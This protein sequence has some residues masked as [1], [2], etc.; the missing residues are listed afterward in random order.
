[1]ELGELFCTAK[2]NQEALDL[3]KGLKVTKRFEKARA[4]L[5]TG[6]A[7]RQMGELDAAEELLLEAIK[8]YPKSVRSLFELGKIYQTKG[9]VEKAMQT[10]RR[11][12]SLVFEEPVTKAVSH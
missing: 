2:R 12:L 1:L 10:Y 4:L 7:K 8:L 9:E 11:A 5:I 6:W 3:V